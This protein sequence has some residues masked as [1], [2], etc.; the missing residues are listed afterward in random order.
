[1]SL[2]PAILHALQHSKEA[3]RN[4]VS[5]EK[6]ANYTRT[7]LQSLKEH[8]ILSPK[9][10][11]EKKLLYLASVD[12]ERDLIG[13]SPNNVLSI[14]GI[15]P[16]GQLGN[17]ILKGK[18]SSSLLNFLALNEHVGIYTVTAERSYKTPISP[19]RPNDY[20]LTLQDRCQ[21]SIVFILESNPAGSS[22]DICDENRIAGG[23]PASDIL[24]IL[25]PESLLDVVRQ[26]F[27]ADQIIAVKQ[28]AISCSPA[29]FRHAEESFEL[30][31]SYDTF[32]FESLILPDY[33]SAIEELMES[34]LKDKTFG[35]HVVKLP[36]E[37]DLPYLDKLEEEY[38][39]RWAYSLGFDLK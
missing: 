35:I 30:T 10:L 17:L 18:G 29:Q 15:N 24:F 2:G 27:D 1:M 6:Q 14:N 16:H 3:S 22:R 13:M 4:A 11:C 12:G 26:V 33:M 8:G 32:R 23:I 38:K 39:G 19:A 36:T 5:L 20:V 37:K 34:R 9:N 21:N 25:V 28:K 31:P 7:I